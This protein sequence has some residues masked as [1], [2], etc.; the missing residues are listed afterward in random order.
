V[1]IHESTFGRG[2]AHLAH[3]YYHSTCME[4][5]QC[6]LRCQVKQLFLPHISA[7]Y[8]GIQALQLAKDASKV[9]PKTKVVKDFDVFTVP[10]PTRKRGVH[11]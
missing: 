5:A 7:R 9:F 6:A 2:E 11:S 4:A 1:L 3:D 10:F 8:V